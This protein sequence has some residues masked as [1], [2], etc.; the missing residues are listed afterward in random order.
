[1]INLVFIVQLSVNEFHL[2]FSGGV[3]F[4]SMLLW[5]TNIDPH[6]KAK[7]FLALLVKHKFN[8]VDPEGVFEVEIEQVQVVYLEHLRHTVSKQ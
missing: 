8:L 4:Q 3:L 5:N 7:L 6:L 2:W 1:V